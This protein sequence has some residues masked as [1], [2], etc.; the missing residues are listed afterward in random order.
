MNNSLIYSHENFTRW[1][2]AI[3]SPIILIGCA[4]GNIAS[5]M[6]LLR[7]RLRRQTT[8]IYLA[9]LCMAEIG[10]CY[11]G[12]LRQ[13]LLD[14]F[15]LDIRT[16]NSWAC[17]SHIYLTYVF[18]RLAP[19]LLALVTLQRYFYVTQRAICSLK[20]TCIQLFC[21]F[22]FVSTAELHLF[23]FYDLTHS[24][25]RPRSEHIPFECTVDKL[26]HNTYYEFRSKIYPKLALV[27]YTVVPLAIII[28]G[29]VLL[30]RTVRKVSQRANCKAKKKRSVTRMLYAVSVLYTVLTSPAS[31]FLAIA[32]ASYQL[33]PAFRLQW[34]LLRLLF[35]LCHS[36]NFLLFCASG[37]F[38]RQEFIS[39]VRS[40]CVIQLNWRS[41]RNHAVDIDGMTKFE[42]EI[43]NPPLKCRTPSN[44]SV[45]KSE[46]RS[47]KL[48][49]TRSAETPPEILKNSKS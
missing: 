24:D 6:V 16:I 22:I 15:R 13:F 19:L 41:N 32:P 46:R 26:H 28:I 5:F 49:E 44:N 38:F 30:V 43:L 35:Y 8:S 25:T 39:F 4:I 12:L 14:A 31:I 2:S 18:L 7:P 20:S 29:N 10:T 47:S 23:S 36:V 34:T 37:T 40:N 45:T 9:V 27:A 33:A 1:I 17:R 3:L 11:T 42:E 21:L 48:N